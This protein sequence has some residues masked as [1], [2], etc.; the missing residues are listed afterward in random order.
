MEFLTNAIR[1]LKEFRDLESAVSSR[2]LPA[3]VTG[4]SGVHKAN[5]MWQNSTEDGSP[6]CSPQMPR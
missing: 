3:A 2:A 5:L 6:P 4:V 1:K